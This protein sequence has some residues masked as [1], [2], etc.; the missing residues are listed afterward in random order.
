VS[1]HRSITPPASRPAQAPSAARMRP[2]PVLPVPNPQADPQADAPAAQTLP[3]PLDATPS[4]PAADVMAAARRD[5][6]TFA[7]ELNKE[8]SRDGHAFG[9]GRQAMLDRQFEEAYQAARRWN[10]ALPM[11]EVTRA[12]DGNTRVYVLSTLLG[13]VCMFTRIE[14]PP[15]GVRMS[16]GERTRYGPCNR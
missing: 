12:S 1:L 6:A 9:N 10:G 8:A 14:E 5:A 3:D 11:K 4:P 13:K 7:R 2:T 15:P 16:P